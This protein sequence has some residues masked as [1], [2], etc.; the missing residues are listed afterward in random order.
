L[1]AIAKQDPGVDTVLIFSGGGGGTTT[2]TGRV[3]VALKPLA[4][5]KSADQIINRLRPKLATVAGATLFLQAVQDVRM[6]GRQSAAQYQYTI[7]SA[8]L[9]SLNHWSPILLKALKGIRQLT[10]MNSDAQNKGLAAK[11]VI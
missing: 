10:D 5:R 7:Q 4:E 11:L 6:G 3:F 8:D 9:D 1:G 2:N